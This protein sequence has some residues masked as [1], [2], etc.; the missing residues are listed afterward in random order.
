MTGGAG[1]ETYYVDDLG[2]TVVENT[3][4]GTD[5][6]RSSVTFTLGDN[7]ESLVL[8]GSD[9]VNGTGNALNNSLTGNTGNNLLSGEA[10]NDYISA[11]G[12]DDTLMGGEG[13]DTL[14]GG[15]GADAMTGGVGNDS[16]IGGTGNDIYAFMQGDGQD[17]INDYDTTTGNS[18]KAKF[19]SGLNPIDLILVNNGNNLDVQVYNSSDL[20]TVQDQNNGTANQ[21]EV[22][23]AGDGSSL[24]ASQVGLL[25]QAMADLSTQNGGMSWT[26]LI[27]NRPADVQQVLAQYWQPPQ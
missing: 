10:G 24:L 21:V 5:T 25:I 3:G 22:F 17:K 26:E 12:G 9:A 8:T 20:L 4:E 2:D 19:G 11:D 6:V 23:E 15:T 13:N 14:V 1:N 27:Q 16:L 18:D 7:L